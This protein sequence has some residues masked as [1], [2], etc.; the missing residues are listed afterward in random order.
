QDEAMQAMQQFEAQMV[1]QQTAKSKQFLADNQRRPGVQTTK[2]GLQ[3]RVAR[4]GRGARPKATDV[5][6]VNYKA[7]YING[8]EFENNGTSPFT[9]P[10]NGV[11][12][13]WQE[14]LQ[15]MP[16]GSKWQIVVPPELGYGAQG[17]PPAIPPNTALVF[18]LELLEI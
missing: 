1:A 10:V 8:Q 15:M 9:T 11:I 6:R 13:G 16:V 14:A 18:E 4:E 3:Y 5:V 17:S 7:S 2:R 12:P